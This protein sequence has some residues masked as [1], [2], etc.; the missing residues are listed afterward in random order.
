MIKKTL[1]F[2]FLL[3]ISFIISFSFVVNFKEK[4]K[5]K[6]KK[7]S[8]SETKHFISNLVKEIV[9]S[10]NLYSNNI[11]KISRNS[12][13][14][15]EIIDF[16]TTEVNK[17]LERITKK[18]ENSLKHL[19]NAEIKSIK[20]F[21]QFN[22]HNFIKLKK[23]V[24][25]ELNDDFYNNSLLGTDTK[26][27]IKLSF[28]GNVYTYISTNIKNYGYNS[29][30]LEVNINIEIKESIKLPML[31]FKYKIENTYPIALKIIQGTIP[32]YY[33]DKFSSNSSS[34]SLPIKK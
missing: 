21:P 33:G 12:N 18:I 10:E 16:D 9:D 3:F 30:Y 14:E 32:N 6:L 23:G 28:V 4:K 31:E 8:I 1:L 17:V 25:F 15:I 20:Y 7:Y 34:Y 26:I 27:P 24:L 19:E 13:N 5:K 22:G 11:F 2:I 29:A